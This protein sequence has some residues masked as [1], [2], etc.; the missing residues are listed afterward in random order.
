V[1][2][3]LIRTALAD[4]A[5]LQE[6]EAALAAVGRELGRVPEQIASIE[7]SLQG[8]EQALARARDAVSEASKERRGLEQEIEAI[9]TVISK[10]Q[11]QL[12]EVKTNEQYRALNQEITTQRRKIEAVEER[13][14]INMERVEELQKTI[15]VKEAE[16]AEEKKRVA[17]EK[18]ELERERARFRRPFWVST[19]ASPRPGLASDSVGRARAPAVNA[20]CGCDRRLWPRRA[21]A[22]ASYSATAASASST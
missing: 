7:K 3:D 8:A 10:Y 2:Q 5:A 4:R 16:L 17:S 18:T 19:G 20:A 6:E 13:I 12:L 9:K 11:G 14:L 1:D 22:S 15:R 21:P